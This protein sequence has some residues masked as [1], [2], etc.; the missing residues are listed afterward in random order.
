MALVKFGAGISEM[1]GKEGGVVYSRNAY[2]AYQKTKVSPTN[3]Q[4]TLQ[5]TVRGRLQSISQSWNGLTQGGKTGWDDLGAIATRVNVFGDTTNYTGYGIF[6]RLNLNRLVLGLSLLTTAPTI[7]TL[8]ELVVAGVT[9][10]VGAATMLAS[11][12]PTPTGAGVA[13]VAYATQQMNAGKN[14]V[15]NLRRF[16]VTE[17]NQ[18]TAWDLISEYT[19]R[20]GDP[21]ED[22]TIHFGFKLIDTATGFDSPLQTLKTVVEA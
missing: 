4:T 3:P 6:M 11:F 17:T 13:I 14:F 20:F 9:T 16:L 5:Q 19:E 18:A 7:P 10:S 1:R 15:K 22:N 2:G 8:P 21:V 12:T